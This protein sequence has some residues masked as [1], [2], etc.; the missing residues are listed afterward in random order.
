MGA[1]CS[2]SRPRSAELEGEGGLVTMLVHSGRGLLAADSDGASDPFV[3]CRVG[4]LG[5]AFDGKPARSEHR[6]AAVRDSL[7]PEW[8]L[9]FRHVLSAGESPAQLE[10][11]VKV[12]DADLFSSDD[13]LGE[14]RVPL[15]KLLEHRNELKAYKLSD[16]KSAR[17][18]V[19]LMA[20][21]GVDKAVFDDVL[22]TAGVAYARG[23]ADG[24]RW[25]VLA[26]SGML[27]LGELFV[28]PGVMAGYYANLGIM[29]LAWTRPAERDAPARQFRAWSTPFGSDDNSF[30]WNGPIPGRSVT[31][32]GHAQVTTRLAE[33]GALF[34]TND[35]N[36]AV[37]REHTIGAC[38][39]RAGMARAAR[40][41]A[42]RHSP[43]ADR[44]ASGTHVSS[45][46][47][48]GCLRAC[49]PCRRDGWCRVRRCARR[50]IRDRTDGRAAVW[51]R[52]HAAARVARAGTPHLR[53]LA[54]TLRGFGASPPPPQM[55][56]S[57][58]R[59]R[60]PTRMRQ[61]QARPTLQSLPRSKPSSQRR[62]RS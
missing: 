30:E 49:A 36:G 54:D 47:R 5:S 62:R 46:R 37:K 22:A 11:H 45:S 41:G 51:P 55:A 7:E 50:A 25:A 16:G 20:G 31:L 44:D 23:W 61:A 21:E 43:G 40:L 15:S 18:E 13:A 59:A 39:A 17:G 6:S 35:A 1:G 26:E 10:L 3:S 33:L 60:L 48:A 58:P 29:A 4:R 53:R 28:S 42:T 56:R 8:K 34:G 52:A 57:R 12:V 9:A 32:S 38:T 14:V 27:R 2:T 19:F 24:G